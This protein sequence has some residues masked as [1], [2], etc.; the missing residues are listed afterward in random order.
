MQDDFMNMFNLQ[1]QS[2]FQPLAKLNSLWVSNLESVTNFQLEAMASYSKLGIKQM[3]KAIEI[4]DAESYQAF[5]ASQSEVAQVLNKK[6]MEDGKQL[7]EMTQQFVNKAES[8]WRESM[9]EKTPA[10]MA[11]KK[12]AA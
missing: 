1:A 5:S 4:K 6:I 11:S 8:I 2:L 10:P 12:K 3:R 7:G 9:P